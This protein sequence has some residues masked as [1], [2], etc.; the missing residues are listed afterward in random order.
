MDHSQ[1]FAETGLTGARLEEAALL[2]LCTDLA[3][4]A[5]GSIASCRHAQ[6]VRLASQL[7][8]SSY[9]S[10]AERLQQ[11]YEAHQCEHCDSLPLTTALDE[12]WVLGLARFRDMLGRQLSETMS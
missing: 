4:S 12:G 11:A 8:G 1:T 10:A 6:V 2:R 3:T 9:P 5:G 7:L